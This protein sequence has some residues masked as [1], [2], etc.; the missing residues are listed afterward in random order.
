MQTHLINLTLISTKDSNL[1]SGDSTKIR[2]SE[3]N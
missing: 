3:F 2:L 1:Y